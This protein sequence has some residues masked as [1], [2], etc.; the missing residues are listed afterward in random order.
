MTLFQCLRPFK[1]FKSLANREIESAE[2]NIKAVF[3]EA[4]D[5]FDCDDTSR[6]FNPVLANRL[7]LHYL[8]Y[9]LEGDRVVSLSFKRIGE[10]TRGVMFCLFI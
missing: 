5:V 4:H 10:N 7:W 8:E 2:H 1:S 9:P 6:L 3:N